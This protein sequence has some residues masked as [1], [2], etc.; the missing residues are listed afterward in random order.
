MSSGI[1][2]EH[3]LWRKLST[4]RSRGNCKATARKSLASFNFNAHLAGF[5]SMDPSIAKRILRGFP[6]SAA[7]SKPPPAS[8]TIRA[9]LRMLHNKSIRTTGTTRK[10]YRRRL[11]ELR[12]WL[13]KSLCL[14][15]SCEFFQLPNGLDISNA[16]ISLSNTKTQASEIREIYPGFVDI[17]HS[18]L[19]PPLV[20]LHFPTDLHRNKFTKHHAFAP[21]RSR[22]FGISFLNPLF[23]QPVLFNLFL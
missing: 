4:Q 17:I 9:R 8:S 22:H 18:L 12:S 11:G 5:P 14:L 2:T 6:K 23:Q 10:R 16:T 15:R 1:N 3:A 21:G 19:Q 13:A 20:N 7:R